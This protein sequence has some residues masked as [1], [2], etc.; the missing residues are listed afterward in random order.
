MAL[1]L[2]LLARSMARTTLSWRLA[3]VRG[4]AR[5]A[6]FR[7]GTAPSAIVAHAVK[8]G[9]FAGLLVVRAGPC[10]LRL[11]AKFGWRRAALADYGGEGEARRNF[12]YAGAIAQVGDLP[13]IEF[14]RATAQQSTR[15]L[16][17]AVADAFQA[18]DHQTLRFPHAAHFAVAAFAQHD[19]EPGMAVAAAD[20]RD[21]VEVRGAIVEFDAILETLDG[22]VGHFAMYAADVFAFNFR[23]RMHQRIGE[24]AIGGQQQQAGRVDIETADCDP[25]RA[26][27]LRQ[28]FEHGRPAFRIV[29]CRDHA[30]GL[31][32]DEDLGMFGIVGDD[33]EALGIKLDPIAGAHALAESGRHAVKLH[34]AA[35]DALFEHAPRTESRV[36]EHL[37]QALLGHRCVVRAGVA[38]EFQDGT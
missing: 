2:A 18:A 1:C 35:F 24:V 16:D 5:L 4:A 19:A 28:L 31:V 34:F 6:R 21:V 32:V 23:A 3:L 7:R 26:L 33:D 20:H 30:I 25:A 13:A 27:D 36:R 11:W 17:T 8:G 38:F 9:E 10:L 22:L 15:Q 12:L 14:F 37:V 29:T